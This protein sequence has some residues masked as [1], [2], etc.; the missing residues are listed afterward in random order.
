MIEFHVSPV[1]ATYDMTRYCQASVHYAKASF[2]H[3]KAVFCDPQIGDQIFHDLKP[4]RLGHLEN[5]P[6]KDC[7]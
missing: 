5:M 6:K 3:Q 7:P 2:H 4:R 1:L